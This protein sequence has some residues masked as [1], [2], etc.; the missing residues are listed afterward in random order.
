M[1]NRQDLV[2]A[3]LD[4][5]PVRLQGLDTTS[6]ADA[7]ANI[8][9]MPLHAERVVV[10]KRVRKV[11][12]SVKRTTHTRDK[13]VE[14]DLNHDQVVVERVAIGRVVESVPEVRQE[15]DVTILP[16]VE[17]EV[18]VIRRLVLKEEV[19]VRRI[20]TTQHHVET[21][22]L[23]EQQVVVTRTDIEN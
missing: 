2:S 14:A 7:A 6:S 13:A 22:S 17:E 21:V 23:R 15:G 19:H 5:V 9:T 11:R 3:S 18:V 20:R 12:V 10:S 1:Q 16:I 4:S 8:L